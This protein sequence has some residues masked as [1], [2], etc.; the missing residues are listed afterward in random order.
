MCCFLFGR[1]RS[2]ILEEERIER[3]REREEGRGEKGG[4]INDKPDREGET[5]STSLGEQFP[6]S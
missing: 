5:V 1:S 3:E 6:P 2:N 4:K